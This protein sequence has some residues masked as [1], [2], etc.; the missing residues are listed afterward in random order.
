MTTTTPNKVCSPSRVLTY[1]AIHLRVATTNA[2]ALRAGQNGGKSMTPVKIKG[3]TSSLKKP[4]N[5]DES[6]DGPCGELSVRVE[7][8]GIYLDYRSN[9]KPSVVE[10]KRLNAG[11]VI[12]LSCIGGQ[13]PVM[14]MVVPEYK[15]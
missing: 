14:L 7:P 15:E 13:P 2:D 3:E 8:F 4:R 1:K 6:R 12:E 9:W 5:W 10:L 11:G